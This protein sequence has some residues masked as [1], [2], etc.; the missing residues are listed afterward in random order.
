[1]T[2]DDLGDD[3]VIQALAGLTCQPPDRER[4][5]RA[6]ARSHQQLSRLQ[7]AR[8]ADGCAPARFVRRVLEPA[9]IAAGSIVF[10]LDVLRRALT[11]FR[12]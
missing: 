10:L 3:P 9:L 12:A 8:S 11:L 4:A 2:A 1:M 6:R 7:A 5:A